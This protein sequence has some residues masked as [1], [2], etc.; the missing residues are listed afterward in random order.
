MSV[1]TWRLHWMTY[2]N[3]CQPG[4]PCTAVLTDI[5]WEALYMRIHKSKCLPD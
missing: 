3:R 2:I 4:L 1:I 5:E